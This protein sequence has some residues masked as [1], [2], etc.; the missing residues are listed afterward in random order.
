MTNTATSRDI[1]AIVAAVQTSSFDESL[2][3]ESS[4]AWVLVV[5]AAIVVLVSLLIPRMVTRTAR[6]ETF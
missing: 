6:V 3:I 5:A 1:G 4:W 2:A